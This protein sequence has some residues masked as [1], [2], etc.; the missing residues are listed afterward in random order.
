MMHKIQRLSGLALVALALGGCTTGGTE[1]K[2]GR[3]LV[4]PDKF[5][6]YSCPQ[7]AI[8]ATT[9]VNRI[10]ELERLK[11]KAGTSFDGRLVSAMAYGS[12]H[13]EM[14]GDLNEL[15]RAAADKNCPPIPALGQPGRR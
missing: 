8:R 14:T 3:L 4:A 7:I 5:L 9:T 6:L 12:E 10:K 1:D 15:R 13:A 11:A 2:A